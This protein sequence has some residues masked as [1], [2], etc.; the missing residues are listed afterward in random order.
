MKKFLVLLLA[1]VSIGT[2]TLATPVEVA[3][4][5]GEIALLDIFNSIG[6]T[7]EQ[8]TTIYNA[9]NEQIEERDAHESELLQLLENY[10]SA[11]LDGTEEEI[12]AAKAAVEEFRDG[13]KEDFEDRTGI[14]DV[15]K[16]TLTV[17]QV[18][19]IQE[20][21][22]DKISDRVQEQVKKQVETMKNNIKENNPQAWEKMKNMDPEQAEK[23]Q[24]Q[25][26]SKVQ[27]TV[28]NQITGQQLGNKANIPVNQIGRQQGNIGAEGPRMN[29][30][31][32][33]GNVVGNVN[34]VALGNLLGRLG[35]NVE[36][37]EPLE[38]LMNT[39]A[40]YAGIE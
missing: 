26:K 9:L 7:Q 27:S 24:S 11:L 32:F 34:Q 22:T 30:Q 18:E 1:V 6:L 23:L 4:L 13:A 29:V 21:F 40:E 19:G 39:L 17:S 2:F 33:K 25:I 16:E 38:I 5:T 15:L 31:G 35:K 37:I 28:K 14:L 36:G 3:E 12:E 8:A 10:K 20:Y